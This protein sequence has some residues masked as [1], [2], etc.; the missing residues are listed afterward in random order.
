M[1][2]PLVEVPVGIA[3]SSD[4]QEPV[5]MVDSLAAAVVVGKA[6][7]DMLQC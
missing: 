2:G 3:D 7:A 6:P 5:D 4:E 1:A